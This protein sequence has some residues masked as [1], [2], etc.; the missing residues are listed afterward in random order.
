VGLYAFEGGGCLYNF[1]DETAIVRLNGVR[2]EVPSRR[3]VLQ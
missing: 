2:F 1:R 3:W